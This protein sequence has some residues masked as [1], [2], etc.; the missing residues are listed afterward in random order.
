VGELREDF[1]SLREGTNEIREHRNEVWE[2]KWLPRFKQLFDD[3]FEE[4]PLQGYIRLVIAE[5]PSVRE[6]YDF[7]PKANKVHIHSKNTWVKPGLK[8]LVK[9]FFKN[10]KT[11]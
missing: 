9:R 1:D 3:R 6:I 11:N 2:Q 4:V 5:P 10:D 7:Y 8:F